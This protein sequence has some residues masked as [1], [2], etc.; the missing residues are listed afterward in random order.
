MRV[1]LLRST[2]GGE[3]IYMLSQKE[4][5]YLLRSLR[6][7]V[8]DTFTAKDSRERYYK[9]FLFD[10][11]SITLEETDKPEETLL[12]GLSSYKGPFVPI[13]AFISVLKG[14]KNEIEVRAL[15]EIGVR[16]IVLM[17]TEFTQSPLSGHQKERIAAIIREAVQQSGSPEPELEGPVSFK[18]ALELADKKILI[19]H[20]S[21]LEKTRSLKEALADTDI[22]TPVSIM[23]GPEGGFSDKECEMAVKKGAVPVLLN[24]NILRAE[25]AAI[26][27]AASV[28]T[29]FQ[30]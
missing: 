24:T 2:Y 29:L 5:N 15:T 27:T 11:D 19:L 12:D 17:E 30:N 26:Y 1:F 4:K 18:K 23:I 3:S 14:K 13:T 10:E 28:Q 7:K 22:M 25:T 9:A 8:N 6:L 20:Q 21:T 16:K